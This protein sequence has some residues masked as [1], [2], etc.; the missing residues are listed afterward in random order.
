MPEY[1]A[2]GVYVEETSFRPKTIEGVGTSTAG[3]VGA[4]RFGPTQGEPELLTSL[5]DFERIY[6]GLDELDFGS[7]AS[8]NYLAQAVRAFFEEGGRR[9][10]VARAYN[11]P[12]NGTGRASASLGGSPPTV[13]LEARHPGSGGNLR[14]TLTLR[15][16]NNLLVDDGGVNILRRVQENDTVA[17]VRPGSPPV[18]EVYDVALGD[19]R[20]TL[21]LKQGNTT[22]DLSTLDAV[23]D[24]VAQL[25]VDVEIERPIAR[26]KRPKLK[27]TSGESY[28]GLALHP[29]NG[30]SLS[31]YF[32]EKT[33]ARRI[34]LYVPLMVQTTLATGAEVA[35]TLFDSDVLAALALSMRD[36][37]FSA[38][39]LQVVIPLI[40]GADGKALTLG[41]F[42]GVENPDGTKSGLRA[43]E[44]LED[45]S[46]VAAPG[47][48]ADRDESAVRAIQGA[49]VSHAERMRYRIAVLDTP[50]GYTLGDV[51]AYRGQFDSAWAAM[52][53]PW[54]TVVDTVTEEELNLPPSGFVAGIYT[55][56]DVN[57][58]VHKTPANE[59]VRLAVGF[60]QLLNKAQQDV[61]NPE[62]INAFR[63]FEGRGYRLWGGRTISSDGEFKYVSTRRYLAYLEASIDRGTQVFVFENNGPQLWNNVRETVSAFLFNEWKSNRLLGFTPDQAYF[64]RC[65]LTTMTQNDLDNGRLICE[66]GVSLLKPAEFVIFRIGQKL[67]TTQ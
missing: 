30:S 56:N 8:T 21:E 55:R 51:R 20:E 25:T 2:P 53:F 59:V 35:G 15:H 50:G 23:N 16:S 65:D 17:L 13:T 28:E 67:L 63:F 34:Q 19:D 11:P 9:L 22:V 44:D 6:G 42:S 33:N 66:V 38:S 61:L 37:T 36:A 14:V 29:A 18:A 43:L 39:D 7:G 26:P 45:I 4:A 3:F 10:Y 58:G 52:Y 27:F 31:N 57:V 1:L 41:E 5:S 62:G 48:T 54:V 12:D 32:A 49:L 60:E 64:V 24:R 47:S 40:G 46:I